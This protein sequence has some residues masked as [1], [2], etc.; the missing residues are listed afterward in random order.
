MGKN[1]DGFS[2]DDMMEIFGDSGVAAPAPAKPAFSGAQA[3]PVAPPRPAPPQAV[4]GELDADELAILAAY[5][6]SKQE[7]KARKEEALRKKEDEQRRILE[8]FEEQRHKT[9]AREHQ[10]RADREAKRQLELDEVRKKEEFRLNAEK[11]AAEEARIIEEFERQ[12]ALGKARQEQERLEKEAAAQAELQALAR[13]Q[14][15]EAEKRLAEETGKNEELQA[16]AAAL[17]K[18]DSRLMELLAKTQQDLQEVA[19]APLPAIPL[20]QNGAAA[21][22]HASEVLLDIES[23]ENE[24]FCFM[25]DETRKAMF[26]FLAPLIGIKAASSMLNKTVERARAKAP[27]VLKDANWTMDGSLREDG[28]VDPERLLRNAGTLPVSSR[29]PDYVAAL[30]ELCTLRVRAVEAGLGATTAA[31]MKG[32]VMQTRPRAVDKKIR[33]EWVQLFYGEILA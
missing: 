12:A 30:K 14:Q 2:L 25:L 22:S 29:V 28:S 17:S 7:L 16:Q 21:A 32:R 26:T 18:K 1:D 9:E 13:Q 23:K 3:A 20:P 6:R 24:A 10:D 33:P 4:D 8:D 15:L 5:E 27:V 19:A 31:E 11:M